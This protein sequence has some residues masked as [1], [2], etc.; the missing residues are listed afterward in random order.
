MAGE[1]GIDRIVYNEEIVRKLMKKHN[2]KL[3]KEIVSLKREY[4]EKI[5]PVK[6]RV[7]SYSSREF[8]KMTISRA[9]LIINAPIIIRTMLEVIVG[10]L[11]DE[12]SKIGHE[13]NG[14]CQQFKLKHTKKHD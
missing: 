4:R 2:V 1:A 12:I 9:N 13:R 14:V 5:K 8:R 10:K 11:E 7:K 6:E 3:N